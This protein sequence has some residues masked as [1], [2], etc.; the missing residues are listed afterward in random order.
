MA[1]LIITRCDLCDADTPNSDAAATP[2]SFTV[3]G[4]PVTVVDLCDE[5]TA[6]VVSPLLGLLSEF[7]RKPNPEPT[8]TAPAKGGKGKGKGQVAPRPTDLQ[9]RCLLCTFT[10]RSAS[11][12]DRHVKSAHGYAP[13]SRMY[14]DP[15]C[16]LCGVACESATGVSVHLGKSPAHPELPPATGLHYAWTLAMNTGDP[17]GVVA[18]RRA[19]LGV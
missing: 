3:D 18:K 5:H 19:E 8:T 4:G 7:G 13:P 15:V 16:P 1:Q 17:H 14:G 6:D 12:I 9:L 11:T 2:H 10:G